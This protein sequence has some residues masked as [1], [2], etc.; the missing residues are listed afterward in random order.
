[1]NIIDLSALPHFLWGSF[2]LYAGL[3]I[4]AFLRRQHRISF[5]FG[6]L[7]SFCAMVALAYYYEITV[8]SLQAKVVW[9]QVTFVFFPFLALLWLAVAVNLAGIDHWFRPVVWK[10]LLV[11]PLATVGFALT[12][13]YHEWFR[14]HFTLEA[15]GPLSMLHYQ[16]GPWFRFYIVYAYAAGLLGVVI[17]IAAGR[18]ATPKVRR[19]IMGMLVAYALPSMFD[20]FFQCGKT[21]LRG[22]NLTVFSFVPSALITAWLV[23]H[24]RLF[25]LE[26]I[27]RDVLL[28]HM[29]E[30]IVVLDTR[31]K[32]VELNAR[33]EEILGVA[34]AEALDRLPDSFSELGRDLFSAGLAPTRVRLKSP[35]GVLQ[36]LESSS[37]ELIDQSGTKVGQL[38]FLRDVTVA[39][40]REAQAVEMVKLEAEQL[41]LREQQRL[42]RDL[43]DGLGALSA[44]LGMLAAR[45]ARTKDAATKDRLLDQI[46][47]L[48][49]EI[50][51]E[52]REIM[53]SLESREFFWGDF[54]HNL[55]R[56][57]ALVLDAAGLT[58][59]L[60]V[61]GEIPSSG[62]G[63]AAGISL[64]RVVR[65]A[66]TNLVKYAQAGEVQIRLAFSDGGCRIE[67][68]DDGLGFDLENARPS[69][70][71]LKNMRHRV[72]ELGGSMNLQ[73][74]SSGTSLIFTIPLAEEA[75]P[76]VNGGAF[77]T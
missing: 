57:A 37:V 5:I 50:G 60:R 70:R 77:L 23:F 4:H 26:P 44:N 1:M 64:F 47:Q 22:L 12:A 36:W 53:S 54:V 39:I 2:L 68:R 28:E 8:H 29:K 63:Y 14:Y 24:Y 51:M 45:G 40:E 66:L 31:G 43:H 21:P 30:A 59:E 56:Y 76:E 20:F 46:N 6:L 13:Q 18:S 69:G 25:N 34:R 61:Q 74:S 33:A 7:M 35:Q 32:I 52:V 27:A 72:E 41:R 3:A 17:M 67:V 58:W 38:Y 73:T 65:E 48:S 16:N 62:P 19:Q 9:M 75:K 55:R 11:V 42:I 15:L 10:L 49:C 71:G